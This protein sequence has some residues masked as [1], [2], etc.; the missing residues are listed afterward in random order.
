MK[1]RIGDFQQRQDVIG[2]V[3]LKIEIIKVRIAQFPGV[4]QHLKHLILR[5]VQSILPDVAALKIPIL[6]DFQIIGHRG[7]VA[8]EP[9][10]HAHVGIC[11]AIARGDLRSIVNGIRQDA[12][13]LGLAFLIDA[14]QQ[15]AEHRRWIVH[16]RRGEDE[17]HPLR[18]QRAQPVCEPD[19]GFGE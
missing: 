1:P 12:G 8:F 2:A 19:A 15:V 17:G 7:E 11:E 9:A 14:K 6:L 13:L 16:K 10:G 3:F 5:K 18:V 4:P